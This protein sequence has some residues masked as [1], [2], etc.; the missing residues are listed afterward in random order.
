MKAVLAKASDFGTLPLLFGVPERW[1]GLQPTP[2]RYPSAFRPGLEKLWARALLQIPTEHTPQEKWFDAIQLFLSICAARNV[3]PFA[4]NVSSNA[5]NAWVAALLMS[6]RHQLVRYLNGNHL[7]D[8]VDPATQRVAVKITDL[9]FTITSTLAGTYEGG[10]AALMR[11]LG[12]NVFQLHR[13]VNDKGLMY[14][15]SLWP[16]LWFYV[17]VRGTKRVEVGYRITVN[18]KVLIPN[19][20]K[21]TKLQVKAWILRNLWLPAVHV[22][23]IT[24]LSLRTRNF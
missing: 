14:A 22:S 8:I 15:A 5:G 2:T 19:V 21:L 1:V 16:N 4:P 17:L 11:L 3:E 24:G 18:H 13:V 10:Q 12:S 20:E 7:L 23:P 9:G 6:T